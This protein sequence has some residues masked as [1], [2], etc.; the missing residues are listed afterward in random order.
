[1]GVAP[2]DFGIW[3]AALPWPNNLW[4]GVSVENNDWAC[5]ADHLR[6]VPAKVRLLSLEPL[7]GP[8][9]D[10]HL[11]GIHWGIVG[12]ESSAR[13]RPMPPGW[14]RNLRDRC[15]AQQIPFLQT[16]GQAHGYSAGR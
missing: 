4:M 5:R 7:P 11:A 2:S 10:R 6:Q 12:G 13:A 1:V 3:P 16:V 9:P 8:L 15:V 14:V